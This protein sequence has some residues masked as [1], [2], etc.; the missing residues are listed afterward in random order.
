MSL[1][2]FNTLSGSTRVR[3]SNGL[4]RLDSLGSSGGGDVYTKG[5]TNTLLLFKQGLLVT[6]TGAGIS[7]FNSVSQ[8]VRKLVGGSN[9]QLSL[10]SE[11]NVII[12]SSGGSGVD[13]N[14]ATFSNNL[15]VNAINLKKPVTIDLGLDVSNG[16]SIDQIVATTLASG[17]I[18]TPSLVCTGST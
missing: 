4:V 11:D 7:A 18:S 5:E 12:E 3:T 6:N 15:H 17:N 10:D 13:P 8:L 9:V 14:V 16:A 2:G 1:V